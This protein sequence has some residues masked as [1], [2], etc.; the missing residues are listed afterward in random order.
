MNDVNFE[1]VSQL[2]LLAP[3]GVG[4]PEPVLCVKGV[5]VNTQ[6]VVGNNHL[7]MRLTGDGASLESIWYNNGN[8]M[9][10]ISNSTVDIAFTPQFN[11]WKDQSNIQLKMI[12][13]AISS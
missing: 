8:F 2:E 3:F 11:N 12:D 13:I 5:S 1:L 10:T 6:S 7:K 4:N 9:K